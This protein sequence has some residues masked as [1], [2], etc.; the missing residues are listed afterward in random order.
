MRV[1]ITGETK[2]K[3]AIKAKNTHRVFASNDE[4]NKF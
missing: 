2:T 4:P 3:E 1:T